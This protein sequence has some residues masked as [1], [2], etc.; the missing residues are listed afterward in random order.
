MNTLASKFQ[1]LAAGYRK[2]GLNN[3][4]GMLPPADK[5]AIIEAESLLGFSLPE[6]LRSIYE[7][8]GGQEYISPGTT[9][10]LG[11][12][13]LLTP[14]ELANSWLMYEEAQRFPG[15]EIPPSDSVPG[16]NEWD[17]W[18]PALIPF[19]NWDAYHIVLCRR[20][21]RIWQYEPYIGLS[22]RHFRDIDALLDAALEAATNLDKPTIDFNAA[23]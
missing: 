15:A 19:A 6:S 4:E 9:G 8:Y 13:R 5:N 7:L 16:E 2:R 20:T 11:S 22:S 12:H 14:L 10:I 1:A 21:H 17:W 3:G 23:E 18:H